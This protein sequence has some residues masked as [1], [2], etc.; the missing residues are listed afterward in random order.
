MDK[1]ISRM[2]NGMIKVIAE[3][4]EG[5]LEA[6]YADENGITYVGIEQFLLDEDFLK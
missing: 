5:G 2:N 1:L 6:I 4:G 3:T